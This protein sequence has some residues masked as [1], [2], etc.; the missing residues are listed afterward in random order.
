[1]DILGPA[2]EEDMILERAGRARFPAPGRLARAAERLQTNDPVALLAATRAYPDQYLFT[3]FPI[4]TV[5]RH[6]LLPRAEVASRARDRATACG[7]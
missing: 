5:W 1:M 6:V 4:G 7:G 2:T 3:G